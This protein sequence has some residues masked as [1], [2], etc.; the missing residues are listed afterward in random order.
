MKDWFVQVFGLLS[1][2]I[3]RFC[4]IPY[5]AIGSPLIN[6]S[7]YLMV[8]GLGIGEYID[9]PLGES[10]LEF[11]IPGL[12]MMSVIRG[13]YDNTM[14]SI[15]SSKYVK[16]L[17]DL[18]ITP[19]SR[20]QIVIGFV[21]ASTTRALLIGT[22]TYLVSSVFTLIFMHHVLYIAHFWISLY[23]IIVGAATFAMLS[24]IISM[25][26]RTFEQVNIFGTFVL[27]PLT[28]LGGVFFSLDM[29]SPFWR[30]AALF[31]PIYYLIEGMRYAVLSQN[32]T[33]LHIEMGVLLAFFSIL[34]LFAMKVLQ[35]GRRYA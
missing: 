16:E 32:T 1:R 28:Y 33:S 18:R 21:G 11:I 2:E 12:M 7:L 22:L 19:L 20:V 23:F 29:L 24:L 30:K 34:F 8:F 13:A 10:Y 14:F 26:S 3:L 17:Q 4:K 27:T 15:L 6:G 9:V 25:L 31:N 35:E 5:Q